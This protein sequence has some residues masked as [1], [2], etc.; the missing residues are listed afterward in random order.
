MHRKKYDC[1][2]GLHDNVG[3][4][5]ASDGRSLIYNI[6]NTGPRMLPC[7]T[8]FPTATERDKLFP[9]DTT[10]HMSCG[11]HLGELYLNCAVQSFELWL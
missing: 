9:N 4:I 5:N 11:I 1:I 8:P 3:K 6:K 10:C 7:G 2:I